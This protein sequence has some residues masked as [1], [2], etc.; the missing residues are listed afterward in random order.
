MKSS[1]RMRVNLREE[2]KKRGLSTH[3]VNKITKIPLRYIE[4]LETGELGDIKKGPR[5]FEAKMRYL[6]LLKLPQDSKLIIPKKSSRTP[7]YNDHSPMYE[8]TGSTN[9]IPQSDLSRLVAH[10]IIFVMIA[11]IC[12]K[13]T[14]IIVDSLHDTTPKAQEIPSQTAISIPEIT[15]KEKTSDFILRTRSHAKATII[16]DGVEKHR[17]DLKPNHDYAYDFNER[18]E[19]WSDN[20]SLLEL[21]LQGSKISPQG[22]VANERKLV[23]EH[24][25]STL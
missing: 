18:I 19:I 21:E 7:S 2:R 9:E 14:S 22:A 8:G 17:N 12:I 13:V 25:T 10:G 1:R 20:V 23:F 6:R 16:V 24:T 15:P 4:A 11:V 3:Q 5:L